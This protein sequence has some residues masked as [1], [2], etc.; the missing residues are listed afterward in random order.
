MGH[1]EDRWEKAVAGQRVPTARQGKGKR[2]RARYVDADG[3][4]RS[5]TF[6]RKGDAERFL[7]AT[8]ADL[9]RG[10]YVDPQRAKLT[11]AAYAERWLAAQPLRPASRRTYEVY[12]RTRILPALGARGLGSITPTDVRA[13]L[14]SAQEEL[15][16]ITV[17]HVHG[18]LATILRAAMEDGYLSCN[19]CARTAPGKGPKARVIPMTTAQVQAVIEAL[20]QRYRVAALLGAGCGLR[21]GEVLGLRIRSVDFAVGELAV[22]EQLQLLPGAP[23]YLA[24]PKTT[25][26][27]RV[28]PMPLV[29]S[30]ALLEHLERE[31]GAPAELVLRSRTGGPIWPNSFY[32]SVWRPAALKAGLPTARF[33]DLRH[34]Y[35][36]ALIRAGESVKTVQA[37]LGHSSAVETLETYTGL[38]PDA[39]QR[40]RAA[41]DGLGLVDRLTGGQTIS[42]PPLRLDDGPRTAPRA[43]AGG[44]D[45]DDLRER[46][47]EP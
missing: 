9:L 33:H 30:S 42:A 29:V 21:V 35:A 41:V 14:R 37:A 45:E 17:H 13:L 6:T 3:R 23:P 5:Q 19:P 20:P 1:V 44:E 8:E 27:I 4:E 10:S 28:V 24:P 39:E 22:V 36:T 32:D 12:L 47:R 38:W 16:P 43:P 18:L 31:P 2:W 11:L 7:I 26:S 34:F 40:T 46:R 25:S 15:A